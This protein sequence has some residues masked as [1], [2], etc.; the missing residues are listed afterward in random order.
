VECDK[1]FPTVFLLKEHRNSAHVIPLKPRADRRVT[2][3]EGGSTESSEPNQFQCDV[4]GRGFVNSRA[5]AVHRG[6]VH[7][8]RTYAELAEESSEMGH[9]ENED[10]ARGTGFDEETRLPPKCL[11]GKKYSYW[12]SYE[13][14]RNGKCLYKHQQLFATNSPLGSCS[15]CPDCR[16]WFPNQEALSKHQIEHLDTK[17]GPTSNGPTFSAEPSHDIRK[18]GQKRKRAGSSDISSSTIGC[19]DNTQGTGNPTKRPRRNSTRQARPH[20]LEEKDLHIKATDLISTDTSHTGGERVRSASVA[21]VNTRDIPLVRCEQPDNRIAIQNNACQIC[22]RDFPSVA[23]RD[24][25]CTRHSVCDLEGGRHIGSQYCQ[26]ATG[27]NPLPLQS[28]WSI[29]QGL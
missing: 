7:D 3:S 27:G 29:R 4:C 1:F 12:K 17:E 9:S 21:Q 15:Q 10:A 18:E 8:K 24:R 14:H 2:D 28:M 22:A 16:G 26:R 25:H 20:Q 23:A 6:L 5:V 19:E 13:N 11:C